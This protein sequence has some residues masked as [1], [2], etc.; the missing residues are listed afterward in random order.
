MVG[1][2]GCLFQYL[3]NERGAYSGGQEEEGSNFRLES[4]L[5][6][7]ND[8]LILKNVGTSKYTNCKG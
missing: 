7:L 1:V 4:M 8:T 5:C 6:Y 3:A 2:K